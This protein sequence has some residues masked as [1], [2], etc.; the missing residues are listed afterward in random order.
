MPA[1]GVAKKCLFAALVLVAVLGAIELMARGAGWVLAWSARTEPASAPTATW[2]VYATGDS[3]TR[4][5]VFGV[6]EDEYPARLEAELD[7]AVLVQNLAVPSSS[8]HAMRGQLETIE[9]ADGQ[10]CRAATV[11]GGINSCPGLMPSARE[12]FMDGVASRDLLDR[13]GIPPHLLV[14]TQE[15][16]RHSRAYRVAT[17]LVVRAAGARIEP[18]V[19]AHSQRQEG[20]LDSC[21]ARIHD[22]LG[23][24][25]DWSQRTGTPVAVLNYPVPSQPQPTTADGDWVTSLIN[26]ALGDA[27]RDHGL[28][29]I[30][31]QACMDAEDGTLPEI[32]FT[33][34]GV[35]LTPWGKA[36]VARCLA[37]E[38]PPWLAQLEPSG[39]ALAR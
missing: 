33:P 13:L 21:R 29:L 6:P 17:Q 18:A 2:Q 35:H 3:V 30:D 28:P 10:G 16:L 19:T 20:E 1:R 27:S 11:L 26:R 24:I 34:D 31:L 37:V 9:G 38:L 12:S 22:E 25:A 7:G 15:L 5:G 4:V 39:C 23:T 8:L 14:N 36:A 32:L